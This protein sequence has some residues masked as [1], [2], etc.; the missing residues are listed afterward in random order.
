MNRPRS[1]TPDRQSRRSESAHFR[2]TSKPTGIE[3]WDQTDPSQE[4]HRRHNHN[5]EKPIRRRCVWRNH[6]SGTP[7]IEVGNRDKHGPHK[8][9]RSAVARDEHLLGFILSNLIHGQPKVG[10]DAAARGILELISHHSVKSDTAGNKK[11]STATPAD[12]NIQRLVCRQHFQCCAQVHRNPEVASQAVARASR[13]D[14]QSRSGAV[15]TVGHFVDCTV[16]A[17]SDNRV[18]SRLG[19][20]TR[21]ANGVTGRSRD[22]DGVEPR[23]MAKALRD[24]SAQ[25]RLIARRPR[26]RI[27]NKERI[28]TI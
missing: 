25:P 15:D 18:E 28:E 17:D 14:T 3:T 12:I 9:T 8:L 6:R 1:G 10:H 2:R 26:P 22:M 24:E 16:T 19:G 21:R 4:R 7:L 20:L 23:I 27:D 5:I 13:Q 11:K